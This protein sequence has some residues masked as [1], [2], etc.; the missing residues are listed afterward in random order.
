MQVGKTAQ[1]MDKRQK[2][3]PNK[4]D[5]KENGHLG[6][7]FHHQ[8]FLQARA[9]GTSCIGTHAKLSSLALLIMAS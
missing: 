7:R 2:G 4:G 1:T 9:P 6:T 8:L 5:K 3:S